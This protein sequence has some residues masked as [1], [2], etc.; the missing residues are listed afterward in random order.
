MDFH[1]KIK[2]GKTLFSFE[3]FPP[4]KTCGIETVFDTL[5]ELQSLR[6]DFMSVTYSAG[7]S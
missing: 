2:E 3:V 7:G 5:S 1:D 4:K 6:P